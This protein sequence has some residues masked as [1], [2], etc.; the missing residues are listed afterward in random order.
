MINISAYEKGKSAFSKN[1]PRQAMNDAHFV[2]AMI[3]AVKLST[4]T[5]RTLKTYYL[6]EWK[7]GWDDAKN[8]VVKVVVEVAPPKKI[9]KKAAKKKAKK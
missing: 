4:E 8:G 7:R 5:P 3:E 6:G 2:S 1:L 9:S